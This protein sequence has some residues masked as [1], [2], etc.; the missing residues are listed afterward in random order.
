MPEPAPVVIPVDLPNRQCIRKA[1]MVM[2]EMF[3]QT[4]THLASMILVGHLGATAVAS[5]GLSLQ[6]LYVV[7]GVFTGISVGATAVVS[8]LTSFGDLRS[9]A[10]A[11]AQ[12]VGL[13]LVISIAATVLMI[14]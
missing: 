14:S 3:L 10:R 1:V 12:A 2:A 5:L 11:S 4:F 9:A 6:P 7:Y 13:S 8:R